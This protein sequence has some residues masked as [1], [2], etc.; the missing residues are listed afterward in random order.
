M[1]PATLE[2]V[3]RVRGLDEAILGR[4]QP[5]ELCIVA[6]VRVAPL[7][8]ACLHARALRAPLL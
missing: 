8:C 6:R 4:L 3:L 1:A 2:D 7:E 5:D